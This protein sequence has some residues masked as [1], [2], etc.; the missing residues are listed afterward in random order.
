MLMYVTLDDYPGFESILL[1]LKVLQVKTGTIGTKRTASAFAVVGNQNGLVG[2]M[3][4]FIS[5]R[6]VPSDCPTAKYAI[7][8]STQG[9]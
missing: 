6:R 7:Y 8:T 9:M 4:N 5:I 1:E 3:F 2:K